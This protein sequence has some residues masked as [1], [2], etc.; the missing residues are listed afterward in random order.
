M[1]NL[2]KSALGLMIV[3]LLAKVLGFVREMVL[4]YAYGTS[5]Y[6]DVYI[7]AMNIPIVLFSVIGAALATTF[8]PLYHQSMEDSGEEGALKFTNNI[9]IIVT[10]LSVLISLLGYICAEYLVRLF[11]LNFDGEK[12]LLTVKFV[13]IMITGLVF[14]GI[15]N[16]LTPYLQIKGNFIVPGMIAVP[17]NIIIIISII[18][19]SMTGNIYILPIGALIGMFSQLLFQ[20]PFAKKNGYKFEYSLNF[21]DKYLKEMVILVIPVLI[22]VCVNQVN[23]M[24]DRSLAS[25]LGDGIIAALNSANRLNWFVMGLFI[26]TLSSVIYPTLSKLSNE[27]NKD[28]FIESVSLG[29]NI[30]ILLILPLTIGAIVLSKPIVRILFERGAFN[31]T[32]TLMTSSALV[33]YSIGMLGQGL[34]NILDRVFY[35]LKDTKT[36]MVNG[37][38]SVVLNIILNIILVNIMGYNGLAL[39]TSLSFLICTLLLFSSLKK[40]IGYFGEDKIIKTTLKSILA[41]TFMGA[42][43]YFGYD[44]VSNLLGTGF[45]NDA[46]SLVVSILIG[47]IVYGIAVII[48]KVDEVNIIMKI[49]KKKLNKYNFNL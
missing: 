21:K 33:F 19:A 48:L 8:I 6:S 4:M 18:L 17:N 38:I 47:V 22:G 30:A 41:A 11:A 39:A 44:I 3:T 37:I 42:V 24:V 32:S 35:A 20:L 31:E 25:G 40:K 45:I 49:I 16:I 12:L 46:I 36:P 10:I 26:V 5:W 43:T 14:I 34:R 9:L 28:K 13:K 29:I 1:S 2:A 23:T 15:S 7:T 27:D